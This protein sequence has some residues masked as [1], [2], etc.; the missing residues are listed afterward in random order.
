MSD[1]GCFFHGD[2]PIPEDAFLVCRECGH[3]WPTRGD[4]FQDVEALLGPRTTEA[5]EDQPFCP[6][7]THD[8]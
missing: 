2:E 6:L 3:A 8:F 1:P 4:F 7:C 5:L